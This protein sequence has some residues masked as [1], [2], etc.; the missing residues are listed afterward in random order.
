MS[1]DEGL[2]LQA[3][4]M[5]EAELLRNVIELAERLGYLVAHVREARGQMLT[6]LPDLII[7]GYGRL[8]FWECKVQS[9]AKGKVTLDQAVWL[10]AASRVPGVDARVVRPLDLLDGSVER[11]LRVTPDA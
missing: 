8:F 10:R 4:D 6:G 5:T 9:L 1:R 7:C 11:M 2:R 3:E